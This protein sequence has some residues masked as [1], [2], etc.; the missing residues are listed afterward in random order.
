MI[1]TS[2]SSYNDNGVSAGKVSQCLCFR[3]AF[4]VELR[5]SLPAPQRL[6]IIIEILSEEVDFGVHCTC[7]I[8]TNVMIKSNLWIDNM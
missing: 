3:L 5:I 1:D 8:V 4:S 7:S 2:P 6:Y